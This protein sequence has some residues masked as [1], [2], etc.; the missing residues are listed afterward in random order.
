MKPIFLIGY[1]GCGKTTLGS[2]LAE[3]M[4]VP[5]IDLDDLIEQRQHKS[6][7][8]I[9]AEIGENGFRQLGRSTLLNVALTTEAIVACGGGTPCYADNMAL[10]NQHGTTVHLTTS[11][12]RLTTRLTMP[13]HKAKRPLI[14]NK[15]DDEIRQFISDALAAR[16]PFYNQ[17]SLQFDSTDIE[18]A[19]ATAIRAEQLKQTLADKH[20]L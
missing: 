10:M 18:T 14:A 5:F 19:E 3:T 13:E 12:D 2:A 4:H 16:L 8:E 6:V 20:L 7:R 9:F 15:S 11:I 17:A 1:M